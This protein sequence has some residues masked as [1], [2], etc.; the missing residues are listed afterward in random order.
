M[1]DPKDKTNILP[2]SRLPGTNNL[3]LDFVEMPHRV[4]DLYPD[5]SKVPARPIAHRKELCRILAKQNLEFQNPHAP[6]LI[7]KMERGE[8]FCVITGQQVGLFTGPMYTI[9]KALSVLHFCRTMESQGVSCVPIFWMATEDHNLSEICNFALLSEKQELHTFS[10][11]ERPV[12]SR[13]PTGSFSVQDPEIR[14]I[15]IRAFQYLPVPEMKENYAN[16][17]LASA[18][19]KTLL[20]VLR[21]FPL[22]IVDPSDA[23]LKRLAEPFF[24]RFFQK[25]DSLLGALV[26]QN[27]SLGERHY[28]VQV[29]M[30]ENRLP[31][32]RISGGE[33][34]PL[35]Q[36]DAVAEL[37]LEELSPSAL[38]RPLF[39]DFLFPSLA[40]IGGPAEIAYFAQLH[41]WYEMMGIEQP[42]LLARA[43]ITILPPST[44]RFLASRNL[45][46]EEL[47]LKEDVL[48]DALLNHED[49]KRVK[50]GIR[51]LG[52]TVQHSMEGLRAQAAKI[53]PTLSR[54]IRTISRKMEY[55]IEKTQRKILS[56]ARR[57]D[58]VFTQQIQKA[59]N[60]V[61]PGEKLQER[62]LNIFSF[63]QR[64]PELITEVYEKMTFE[65]KG[66]QWIHI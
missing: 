7:K 5:R 54:S 34:I 43:G 19:A 20:W 36:N 35:H 26:R 27:Q 44:Q 12:F 22:L 1:S 46:P 52:T 47:F 24:S 41:P 62:F 63:H 55:Q 13:K 64:L 59:R 10:L 56:A 40:Y 39:Q 66:H 8:T 25:R 61:F 30:E 11:K 49:L 53:D 33:R 28:P 42:W 31:M 23:G 14:K 6:A 45:N 4:Q 48:F 32:F 60:I 18:F 65:A 3:F 21:D 58:Q 29:Q 17:T 50:E 38:L 9:W 15:L 51:D 16:G 57:K 2:F 37:P